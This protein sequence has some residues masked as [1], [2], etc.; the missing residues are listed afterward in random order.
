MNLCIMGFL[1]VIPSQGDV[2]WCTAPLSGR[3]ARTC[4]PFTPQCTLV[5]YALDYCHSPLGAPHCARQH[6]RTR[7]M[8]WWIQPNNQMVRVGAARAWVYMCTHICGQAK[9][10]VFCARAGFRS[11]TI[12]RIL[13]CTRIRSEL[14]HQKEKVKSFTY[15]CFIVTRRSLPSTFSIKKATFSKPHPL[16]RKSREWMGERHWAKTLSHQTLCAMNTS[17]TGAEGAS[18]SRRNS[19]ME[20]KRSVYNIMKQIRR[21]GGWFISDSLRE[22][23]SN[24]FW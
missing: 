14:P 1:L 8:R 5:P 3:C 7:E 11:N 21:R 23:A 17:F 20:L 12:T 24:L 10:N 15:L 19:H 16:Q 22:T 9:Y 4:A 18:A 6:G 2:R 13:V